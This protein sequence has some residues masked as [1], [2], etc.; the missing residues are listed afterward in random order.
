MATGAR[1][2]ALF[3]GIPPSSY[4]LACDARLRPEGHRLSPRQRLGRVQMFDTIGKT[5]ILYVPEAGCR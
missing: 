1:E 2:A 3:A 5:E 4:V